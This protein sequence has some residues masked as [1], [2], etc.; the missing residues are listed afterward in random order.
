MSNDVPVGLPL[1]ERARARDMSISAMKDATR[2]LIEDAM[3]YSSSS[4]DDEELT[5][6]SQSGRVCRRRSRILV[7]NT[8]LSDQDGDRAAPT[9]ARVL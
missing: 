5:F 6:H 1:G 4:S 9:P 7:R 3:A 8:L 2:Y